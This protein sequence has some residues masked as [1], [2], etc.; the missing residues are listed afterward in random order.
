MN[1]V[2]TQ[3]INNKTIFYL[4]VE[5]ENIEI[6]KLLLANNNLNINAQYIYNKFINEI[7]NTIFEWYFFPHKLIKQYFI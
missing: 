2:F 7:E 1:D 4:A 3:E 6:I 5:K